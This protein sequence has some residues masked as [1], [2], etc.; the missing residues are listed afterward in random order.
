MRFFDNLQRRFALGYPAWAR[1]RHRAG[2]AEALRAA[3]ATMRRKKYCLLATSGPDGVSARVLQPFPPGPGFEVWFGTSAASRK[4]AEARA[5]PRATVVYEDDAKA[6]CVVL[7]GRIEVV[8]SLE[9][10]R[11]RFMPTWWAFWPEGPDSADYV[12]LRFV[13]ESMEVWD[14]TR[15]ITPEP[16][17]L[18]AA[19]LVLRDGQ[20]RESAPIF[21]PHV[22]SA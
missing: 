14:A 3:R 10:R 8:E 16:F 22:T 15:H 17:G 19:R 9:A 1:R 11:R 21:S 20:W 2:A 6:A 5:D 4:V 12:L 13:P 7:V 18:R